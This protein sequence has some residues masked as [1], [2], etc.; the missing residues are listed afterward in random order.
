MGGQE[1]GY[2]GG[3]VRVPV[4]LS[5]SVRLCMRICCGNAGRFFF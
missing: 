1:A 3:S 4:C 2:R 5:E